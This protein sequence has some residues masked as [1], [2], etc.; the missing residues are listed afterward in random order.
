MDIAL[1]AIVNLPCQ[2]SSIGMIG[3]ATSRVLHSCIFHTEDNHIAYTIPLPTLAKK[4][5]TIKKDDVKNDEF[6]EGKEEYIY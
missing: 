3:I 1:S 6:I 2:L 4:V 5:M